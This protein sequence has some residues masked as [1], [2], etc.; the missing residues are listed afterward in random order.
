[1]CPLY[2]WTCERSVDFIPETR[3]GYSEV[4]VKTSLTG[5]IKVICLT[6]SSILDMIES[7]VALPDF[8][9][10]N[11]NNVVLDM[12]EQFLPPDSS[13]DAYETM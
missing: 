3:F 9:S 11:E 7:D 6:P 2:Q 8:E 12:M 5:P 10:E 1:M 4:T 13:T